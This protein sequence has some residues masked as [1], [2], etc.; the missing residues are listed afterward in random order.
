[1][2]TFQV[3]IKSACFRKIYE[4]TAASW[5]DAW[6]AAVDTYGCNVYVSVKPI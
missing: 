6:T 1:M 2:T 3:K 4:I 5:F